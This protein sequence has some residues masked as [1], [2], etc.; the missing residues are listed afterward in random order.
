[1][2]LLNIITFLQSLDRLLLDDDL[3]QITTPFVHKHP[4]PPGAMVPWSDWDQFG[5]KHGLLEN[6]L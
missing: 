2:V 3:V 1:M 4:W 5:F 6:P